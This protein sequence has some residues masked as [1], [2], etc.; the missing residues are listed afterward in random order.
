[1]KHKTYIVDLI[2]GLTLTISAFN[3]REAVI[4]AQAEAIRRG[5]NYELIKVTE[6]KEIKHIIVTNNKYI[7]N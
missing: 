6:K 3:E 7:F 4:L 2:G 5:C 1:M